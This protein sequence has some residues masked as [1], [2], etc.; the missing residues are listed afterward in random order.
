[1]LLWP[2]ARFKSRLKVIARIEALLSNIRQ[3]RASFYPSDW[4]YDPLY[5]VE[6]E[7]AEILEDMKGGA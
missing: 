2:P 1:M 6:Q 4:T 3:M 7:L 5:R